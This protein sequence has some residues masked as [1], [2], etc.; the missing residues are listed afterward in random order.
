MARPCYDDN[1]RKVRRASRDAVAE[2]RLVS[3]NYK[4]VI[5]RNPGWHYRS[6]R[7]GGSKTKRDKNTR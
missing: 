4:E 5:F 6:W 3:A 1:A 2:E 7:K